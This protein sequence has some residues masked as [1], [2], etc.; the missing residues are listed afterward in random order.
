MVAFSLLNVG[1]MRLTFWSDGS[2]L[3]ASWLDLAI[4]SS[5][6]ALWRLMSMSSCD[7]FPASLPMSCA[8][9]GVDCC[10]HEC[11][12]IHADYISCHI[13]SLPHVFVFASSHAIVAAL[14]WQFNRGVITPIRIR[15]HAV[16]QTRTQTR[17]MVV[18]INVEES[19]DATHHGKG[20]YGNIR[21]CRAKSARAKA[22]SSHSCHGYGDEA[23]GPVGTSVAES[24]K[25][26]VR[27]AACQ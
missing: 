18:Y 6:I 17:M 11:I 12:P 23:D 4:M 16:F 13:Q 22:A 25:R 27:E 21:L 5:I 19:G 9:P 10:M 1:G 20:P 3:S 2:S 7:F 8:S 24:S 14:P 26:Q 15:L